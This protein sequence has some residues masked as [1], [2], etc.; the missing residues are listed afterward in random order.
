MF[1]SFKR[2][3]INTFCVTYKIIIVFFETVAFSAQSE[4]VFLRIIINLSAK[5]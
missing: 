2:D 1:Y 5:A 3:K 4:D